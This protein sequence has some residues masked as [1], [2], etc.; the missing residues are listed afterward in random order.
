MKLFTHFS[1][2]EMIRLNMDDFDRIAA[3]SDK[4]LKK[5]GN[6]EKHLNFEKESI[7]EAKQ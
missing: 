4:A 7:D 6:R 2:E 3:L 5:A 1:V